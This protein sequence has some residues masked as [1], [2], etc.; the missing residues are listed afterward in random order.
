MKRVFLSLLLTTLILGGCR[1]FF[2]PNPATEPAYK[3]YLPLIYLNPT[4][5]LGVHQF[6]IGAYEQYMGETSL[7]MLPIWWYEIEPE[8]QKFVW[9]SP[10]INDN[11]KQAGLRY[12]VVSFKN[13][14]EW[15]KSGEFEC[16]PP[17][18]EYWEEYANAIIALLE[19]YPS[20]DGVSIWNEP[21]NGIGSSRFSGCWGIDEVDGQYYAKFVNFVAPKI[22]AKFPQIY[23]YAGELG[24]IRPFID[25][26]ARVGL[27]DDIDYISYH[28]YSWYGLHNYD[29]PLEK[30]KYIKDRFPDIPLALTETAILCNSDVDIC[31]VNF[32]IERLEY[33]NHVLQYSIEFDITQIFWFTLGGNNWLNS[34]LIRKGSTT[35]VW[36]LYWDKTNNIGG[37]GK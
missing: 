7:V 19:Q 4:S 10:R 22:K 12:T 14:P 37:Y 20:I 9:N 11:F 2:P 5:Q 23:L 34:D 15:A 17:K 3:S 31:D 26:M 25:G 30:A 1:I 18:E 8:Y 32:E 24:W 16:T 28:S 27:V 6:T 33:L 21:D 35:P 36:E 29:L 13:S